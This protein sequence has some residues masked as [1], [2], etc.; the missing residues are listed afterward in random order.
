VGYFIG[1]RLGDCASLTH[2][3]VDYVAKTLKYR[4]TKQKRSAPKKEVT[5]P[6]HLELMTYF[7][8]LPNRSGPIFPHLSKMRV[9]GKSG[10]SLTFRALMD[11]AGIKYTSKAPSG[12]KGRNV[13]SLSFH[14]LRKSFNTDLANS[15]VSQEIRQKLIGHASK[16]VNDGY[17]ELDL[18]TFRNAI[19]CLAPL[20]VQ[21]PP[22]RK[23]RT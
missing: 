7:E 13:H 14:S 4:P 20:S 17:T 8:S 11:K 1:A 12:E 6:I 22:A 9:G 19:N 18:N 21:S 10:L 16:D 3:A 23:T 15:S 2:E 5:V